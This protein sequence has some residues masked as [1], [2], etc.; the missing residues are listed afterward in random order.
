MQGLIKDKYKIHYLRLLKRK[1]RYQ[2]CA[3]VRVQKQ[4]NTKTTRMMLSMFS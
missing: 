3:A 4:T 1:L 2:D